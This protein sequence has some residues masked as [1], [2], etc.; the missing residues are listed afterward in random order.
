LRQIR[1]SPP[2]PQQQTARPGCPR[3]RSAVR[4]DAALCA[5]RRRAP[6]VDPVIVS[7]GNNEGAGKA[8]CQPHPWFACNKKHAVEPQVQAASGLPCAMVL[9]LIR[10]L[11]ADRAFL[12]P[13]P[14]RREMRLCELSASGGAP[15]PHDFAVR[16]IAA[17][18]ARCDRSWAFA[19]SAIRSSAH[20][21]VASTASHPNVRDD[22][23]APSMRRD[24]R[25]HKS[26]FSRSRSDLFFAWGLD[27]KIGKRTDLPV[28]QAAFANS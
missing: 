7:P 20:D 27:R 18:L 10:A 9:R 5:R 13:S 4:P 21:S 14:A 22:A 26:D 6:R 11:P 8:G 3:W 1:D 25:I 2:V 16:N 28:G 24:G 12:P 17:R 23:Y 15:E 19:H